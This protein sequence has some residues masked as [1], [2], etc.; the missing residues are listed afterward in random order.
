MSRAWVCE[1]PTR[2][3][4]ATHS[5]YATWQT[6]VLY[7]SYK[8]SEMC[9]Q[10]IFWL[11]GKL[12]LN[13]IHLPIRSSLTPFPSRQ[14]TRPEMFWSPRYRVGRERVCVCACVCK[15]EVIHVCGEM[16]IWSLWVHVNS[17]LAEYKC[18]PVHVLSHVNVLTPISTSSAWLMAWKFQGWSSWGVCV[19]G[20]SD[21]GD[22]MVVM[23]VGEWWWWWWVSDGG[24]GS[25]WVMVVSEWVRL[26]MV[27]GE[28]VRLV[29]VL[30]L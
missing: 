19:W 11:L 26:V 21:G 10:T 25:E 30:E 23:V 4:C 8:W 14:L 6:H 24:D 29:I 20:G 13:N 1:L 17:S 16:C 9:V 27:V 22:I 28:W 3:F 15:R 12:L 5:I 18:I 2:L 7:C